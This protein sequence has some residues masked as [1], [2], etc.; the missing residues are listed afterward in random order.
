M[1]R[2]QVTQ[3]QLADGVLTHDTKG[4][5]IPWLGKA[6][7]SEDLWG[8]VHDCAHMIACRHMLLTLLQRSAQACTHTCIQTC[9]YS[10]MDNAAKLTAHSYK[11]IKDYNLCLDM[12]KALTSF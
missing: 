5:H 2:R 6:A 3:V 1:T 10:R 8:G 7:V 4:V 11:A 12:S 9:L